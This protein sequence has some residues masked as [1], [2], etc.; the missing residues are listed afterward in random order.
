[1][2]EPRSRAP[3]PTGTNRRSQ[4]TSRRRMVIRATRT[5]RALEPSRPHLGRAP[6]R[7]VRSC[8][9][10]ERPDFESAAAAPARFFRDSR[11]AS[12]RPRRTIRNFVSN[13]YSIEARC[14]ELPIRGL[15]RSCA[16]ER[17]KYSVRRAVPLGSEVASLVVGESPSYRLFDGL[18]SVRQERLEGYWSTRQ[19]P[20]PRPDFFFSSNLHRPRSGC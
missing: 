12:T 8:S 6:A 11:S 13:V 2:R 9:P 10:V 14:R 5:A 18:C 4:P 15:N 3:G 20:R 1:M 16:E 7:R 17:D 19:R